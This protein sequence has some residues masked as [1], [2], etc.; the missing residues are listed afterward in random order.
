MYVFAM[1]TK[2]LQMK[3]Q[4]KTCD[5]KKINI[6]INHKQIQKDYFMKINQNSI[7][8]TLAILATTG[9]VE[10]SDTHTVSEQ[11]NNTSIINIIPDDTMRDIISYLPIKEI[12]ELQYCSKSF[13]NKILEIVY[14]NR[15]H[16]QRAQYEFIKSYLMHNIYNYVNRIDMDGKI[17]SRMIRKAVKESLAHLA[18]DLT[19]TISNIN[20][21]RDLDLITIAFDHYL[22]TDDNIIAI[23]KFP[24]ISTHNLYNTYI[25]YYNSLLIEN[26]NDTVYT[27]NLYVQ[28]NQHAEHFTNHPSLCLV[29]ETNLSKILIE[30]DHLP[31][32]IKHLAILGP[33]LITIDDYFLVG[34]TRL[35]TLNLSILSHVTNI[36]KNFLYNCTSLQKIYLN[37]YQKNSELHYAIQ[38]IKLEN[39]IEWK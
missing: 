25:L 33:N 6:F 1:I 4:K 24:I 35:T 36:G 17:V 34:C 13:R 8:R 3:K 30:K 21:K 23:S 22:N 7:L 10:A 31:D 2:K 26:I 11:I 16:N 27:D 9:I 28:I 18:S 12:A 20:Q 19:Q 39:I 15:H 5:N 14:G 38:N 29:I 37:E 32:S